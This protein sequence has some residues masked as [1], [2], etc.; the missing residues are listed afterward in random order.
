MWDIVKDRLRTDNTDWV[1]NERWEATKKANEELYS[2]YIGTMSEELTPEA[3]S[4]KWPFP[5]P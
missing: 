4:K 5:P 2:M 3:A 1:P